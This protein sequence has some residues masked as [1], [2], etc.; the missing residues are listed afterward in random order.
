M[1][2]V[3]D[4]SVSVCVHLQP[5]VTCLSEVFIYFYLSVACHFFTVYRG[6][7]AFYFHNIPSTRKVQNQ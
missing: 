6:S 5:S 2:V 7:Y 1:P 3:S 4:F